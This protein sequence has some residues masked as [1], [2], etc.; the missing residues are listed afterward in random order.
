M[1]PPHAAICLLVALLCLTAASAA[2]R[3]LLQ[4]SA[5]ATDGSSG[6]QQASADASQSFKVALAPGTSVSYQQQPGF[7]R[8]SATTP[9]TAITVEHTGTSSEPQAVFKVGPQS[10]PVQ[11]TVGRQ[12]G[13]A[14]GLVAQQPASDR[15]DPNPL[16]GSLDLGR[17]GIT[18]E[19]GYEQF[20]IGK[21]GASLVTPFSKVE[22]PA[23]YITDPQATRKAFAALQAAALPAL[24]SFQP[25]QE[26]AK[27]LA[28]AAA[29]LADAPAPAPAS[30]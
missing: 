22:V 10:D 12:V 26:L 6:T 29:L 11:V 23:S 24:Q 5:P 15:D 7:P 2:P 3:R 4:Q 25:A 20:K 17:N 14:T 19:N 13:V 27:A 16:S 18:Q 1:P 28:P 21:D 8:V 9:A 30:L